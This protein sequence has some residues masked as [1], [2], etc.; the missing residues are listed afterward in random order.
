MISYYLRGLI[1]L[2]ILFLQGA[3][4]PAG[5]GTKRQLCWNHWSRTGVLPSGEDISTKYTSILGEVLQRPGKWR[6]KG[7]L[8]KPGELRCDSSWHKTMKDQGIQEFSREN[9]WI[10]GSRL[11]TMR[12]SEVSHQKTAGGRGMEF[13]AFTRRDMWLK[14]RTTRKMLGQDCR[15]FLYRTGCG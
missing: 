14:G 11:Q 7:C 6:P 12:W 10:C 13:T 4:E 1:T 5:V 15:T 2:R 3:P 9:K 8:A